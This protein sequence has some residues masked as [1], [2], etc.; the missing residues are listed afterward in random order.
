MR[1]LEELIERNLGE[2]ELERLFEEAAAGDDWELGL[3]CAD[4]E[5]RWRAARSSRRASSS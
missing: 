4:L 5:P 2:R 3:L 1:R